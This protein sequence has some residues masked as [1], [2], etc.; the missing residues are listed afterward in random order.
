MITVII[1]VYNSGSTLER[2]INSILLQSY[3]D[4]EIIIV[5]DDS[6]DNSRDICAMYSGKYDNILTIDSAHIGVSGARN[7]GLEMA[8]GEFIAFCDADDI[9]LS[10]AFINMLNA[11]KSTDAAIGGV[12][13]RNHPLVENAV[14]SADEAISRFFSND[15]NR[16]LGTVYGKLFRRTLIGQ[17]IKFDKDLS[18]GEDSEFLLRYLFNCKSVSLISTNVYHHFEN[19][20]GIIC[21]SK[22][23]SYESAILA[24][25]KMI[26]YIIEFQNWSHIEEAIQDLFNVFALILIR[27]R[28]MSWGTR[29]FNSVM[30][31]LDN[32]GAEI[33]INGINIHTH[34][35]YCIKMNRMFTA[36]ENKNGTYHIQW[37]T[38]LVLMPIRDKGLIQ[39][40]EYETGSSC[41]YS[42]YKQFHIIDYRDLIESSEF[43]NITY[44]GVAHCEKLF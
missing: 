40:V 34:S 35:K 44:L 10:D 6:R 7:L 9:Y 36:K 18:V 2:C 24:S 4:I 14:I 12:I 37:P 26:N 5:D 22:K 43:E 29:M 23:Y 21:S 41:Q 42:K 17:N 25:K 3:N 16:I 19:P 32:T 27:M 1:P 11:I 8:K 38:S 33:E 39:L 30:S 31:I 28:D 20:L 15:K 13:K